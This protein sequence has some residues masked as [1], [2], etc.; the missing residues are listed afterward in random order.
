MYAMKTMD[1]RRVKLKR[2]LDLCWNERIIL[3]QLDSPFIVSLSYAFYNKTELYLVMD[4]MLGGDMGFWLHKK[5]RLSQEETA[6]HA[7]RVFLA[8]KHMHKV[9]K[10]IYV[11][12]VYLSCVHI[13]VAFFKCTALYQNMPSDLFVVLCLIYIFNFFT[14]Q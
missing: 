10:Y 12:V 4:L 2:A 13:C 1:R 5:K 7:G 6:Y 3:G 14:L 11:C 8:L 9:L